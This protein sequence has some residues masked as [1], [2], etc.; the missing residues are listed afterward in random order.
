MSSCDLLLIHYYSQERRSDM[1]INLT[2]LRDEPLG[3]HPIQAAVCILIC[4]G[5][6]KTTEAQQDV[7]AAD[8]ESSFTFDVDSL[9]DEPLDDSPSVSAYACCA[10]CFH[11]TDD[12]LSDEALDMPTALSAQACAVASMV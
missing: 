8:H 9:S 2:E 10:F 5:G 7:V 1:T 6:W 3:K 11:S 12:G 4:Y